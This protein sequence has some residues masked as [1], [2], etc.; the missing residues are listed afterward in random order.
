MIGAAKR[1]VATLNRQR[2]MKNNETM[3][4]IDKANKSKKQKATRKEVEAKARRKLARNWAKVE[5]GLKYRKSTT[6]ISCGR[7]TSQL[8]EELFDGI[9][10]NLRG[11]NNQKSYSVQKRVLRRI[12]E[13]RQ[14]QQAHRNVG[15]TENLFASHMARYCTNACMRELKRYQLCA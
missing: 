8:K 3:K 10:M 1:M 7:I 2:A 6:S 14:G 11:K 15:R 12:V 5:R 4:T 9:L 13:K